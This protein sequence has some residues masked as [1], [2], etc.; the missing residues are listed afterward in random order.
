MTQNINQ[1]TSTT[2]VSTDMAVF[3]PADIKRAGELLRCPLDEASAIKALIIQRDTGLSITRGEISIV[4][5]NGRPTVMINKQGYLSYASR[6]PDYDG[7]ES[8][9][10]TVDGERVAWCTV[11]N[12]KISHPIKVRIYESE[13]AKPS[14]PIW[15]EKP[16]YML[17]KT[18]VSLALRAAFPI[19]NGTYTDDEIEADPGK[20]PPQPTDIPIQPVA[21]SIPTP[22]AEPTP[23]PKPAPASEPKQQPQPQPQVKPAAKPAQEKPSVVAA[24]PV[25]NVKRNVW[26][27]ETAQR[28][29][30]RF[31]EEHMSTDVFNIAKLPDGTF[32]GDMIEADFRRQRSAQQDAARSKA[33]S[34]PAQGKPTYTPSPELQADIDKLFPDQQPTAPKQATESSGGMLAGVTCEVCGKR[35]LKS[36]QSISHNMCQGHDLCPEHQAEYL[37]RRATAAAQRAPTSQSEL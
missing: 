2:A 37:Q 9:V 31:A 10:E 4:P 7:Y 35:L 36:E 6:H 30:E 13:Y 8:G 25:A 21:E 22:V 5:F 18:A 1:S 24:K 32:D 17:E 27:P 23:T 33:A 3:S 14:S 28:S 15:K 12:R 16:R 19:L 11:Y 20:I 26:T 34:T 29:L